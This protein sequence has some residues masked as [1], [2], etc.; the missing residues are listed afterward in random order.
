MFWIKNKIGKSENID[1]FEEYTVKMQNPM[2]VKIISYEKK[3][4][5][6]IKI[7]NSFYQVDEDGKVLK[8]TAVKPKDIPIITGLDI[9]K[10]SMYNVLE[11]GNKGD[12]PALTNMF[13]EL[14]AY[15]LKPKKIDI[16]RNCEITMYIKDLKVQLGKNNNPIFNYWFSYV[17]WY[18]DTIFF[19]ICLILYIIFCFSL[20]K[21][22]L[23]PL[24]FFGYTHI[25]L[26]FNITVMCFA[27]SC[28]I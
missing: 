27:K 9:K 24:I 6:Y 16:N 14:D 22:I 12:I 13:K 25:S 7:Y 2:K 8:I 26:S 3:L 11:T 18:F 1:L 20:L 10:A 28:I 19:P 17:W 15:K 4:K 5:G 21:N 23:R